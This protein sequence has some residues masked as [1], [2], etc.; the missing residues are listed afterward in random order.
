MEIFDLTHDPF[1]STLSVLWKRKDG[2]VT[3][4]MPAISTAPKNTLIGTIAE[5]DY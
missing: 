5:E 3:N 2:L 1:R 4:T